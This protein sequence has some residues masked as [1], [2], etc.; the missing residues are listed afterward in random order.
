MLFWHIQYCENVLGM[1]HF[2]TICMFYIFYGVIRKYVYITFLLTLIVITQWDFGYV[3]C[4]FFPHWFL[5]DFCT[6]LYIGIIPSKY[7]FVPLKKKK[8]HSSTTCK[9]KKKK[10]FSNHLT[11]IIRNH[12]HITALREPSMYHYSVKWDGRNSLSEIT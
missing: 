5:Y 8:K 4:L 3:H 10:P 2:F 12:R 11:A 1:L 9:K 6:G 7:C